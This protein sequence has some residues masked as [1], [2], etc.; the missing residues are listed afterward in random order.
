VDANEVNSPDPDALVVAA[1]AGSSERVAAL[2]A[3]GY[4]PNDEGSA[5]Q[6]PLHAAIE[7]IE[8]AV[9]RLLLN[10]GADPNKAGRCRW[11]PIFRAVSI[12][13]DSASQL[14][15]AEIQSDAAEVIDLLLQHGA[16]VSQPSVIGLSGPKGEIILREELPAELARRYGRSDLAARLEEAARLRPSSKRGQI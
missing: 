13:C 2:I 16:D 7:N 10:R 11:S 15:L 8:L 3:S 12:A 1:F 9:V 6:T 14:G 4:D 5:P